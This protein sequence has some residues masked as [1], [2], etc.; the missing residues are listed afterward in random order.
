[1]KILVVLCTCNLALPSLAG[2][3]YPGCQPMQIAG[4]RAESLYSLYLGRLR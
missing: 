3:S 2:S 4:Y 1:M